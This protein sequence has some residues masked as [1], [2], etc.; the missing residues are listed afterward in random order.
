MPTADPPD[1]S[2]AALMTLIPDEPNQPLDM[3]Q[4]IKAIVDDGRYFILKPY[5]APALIVCLARL[6][7]KTVGVMANQ[8][9][10]NGGALGPDECDKATDFIVMCDSFNIPLIFLVD[11][12]GYM[13]GKTVEQNRLLTKSMHWLQALLLVTVPKISVVIRKAY[14]MAANNMCVPNS[15]SD[16]SAALTTADIRLMS[17]EVAMAVAKE[18]EA[19]GGPFQAAMAGSIDDIIEPR[20]I[21]KYLIDCLDV[22]R[23]QRG[24]FVSRHLLQTWPTGF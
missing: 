20:D 17:P 18:S 24:N 23:G 6:G 13:G 19:Q 21:R 8:G 15:S 7:G 1:R 10:Y 2:V 22:L 4:V 5:F 3:E 16:F 11:T 12:P 14:G 9:L